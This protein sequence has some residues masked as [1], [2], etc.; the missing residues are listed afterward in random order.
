MFCPCPTFSATCLFI[1]PLFCMHVFPKT[2]CVCV[3]QTPRAWADERRRGSHKRSAS[4]G[5][6]DQLKEVSFS[7]D[8]NLHMHAS[9]IMQMLLF[10]F[11]QV[12]SS[13]FQSVCL[14]VCIYSVCLCVKPRRSPNCDSSFS[15]ANA[16]AA[17]GGTKTANRRSTAAIP[18][19]SRR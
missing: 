4:C 18:S 2:V 8:Y 11:L 10:F 13:N 5:S 9:H 12:L 15:A 1:Q 16:A 19:Y 7:R 17:I 3:F 6:T 14:Y